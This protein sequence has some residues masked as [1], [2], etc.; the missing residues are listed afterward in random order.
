MSE[1]ARATSAAQVSAARVAV[2]L[3][4]AGL[5]LLPIG[6]WL[7][8]SF[9]RAL[10]YRA[11]SWIS[12][13]AIVALLAILLFKL[14]DVLSDWRWLC[15]SSARVL[16]AV[17]DMWTRRPVLSSILV[18]FVATSLY[19][20][21]AWLVF[22]A[23][24]LL[25]DEVV[26][27]IQARIFISG[28]L[29]LPVD[30]HPE[31]RS[32]MHM[33]EQGNRW[34]G[35]FPPGGPA[36]LAL[37]DVLHAPWI[38]NPVCAGVS[39]VA[40]AAALRWSGSRPGVSLGATLAFAFA[41]FVVFQSA[42]YMNHVTCLMW[43]LVAAAAAAY[44]A[45]TDTDAV[46]P[47]LVCG[48][49]LGAAA[50]IRPLD[51]AAWALPIAAWLAARAYRMRRWR[52][53]LSSGVGVALP[54]AIMMVV[55]ARMTGG[56]LTFGY[57]VLWGPSH[58]L[59]FHESPWGESHT[60]VRGLALT[61]AYLNRLNEY[62]FELPIP[63][64]LPALA[65]L[66]L[67]RAENALDRF[68][69][70]SAALIVGAYFAY[71]HDGFYLGPRFMFALAPLLAL[72]TARLPVIV[73]DRWPASVA[74]RAVLCAYAASALVGGTAVL[75]YR[76]RSYRGGFES[77][78][79][80]YDA[81]VARA[82]AT[83]ATILVRESWGAQVIARLWALGVSRSATEI[84]YRHVD[85]CGLD[86][87]ARKLEA[88][89]IRGAAAE[90]E[91]RTLLVDS[92]RV[93]QS[94]ASPDATERMLPGSVYTAECATRILED[95]AGYTH[96]PPA[97]LARNPG[98]KWV[99]DLHARDTLVLGT[100]PSNIWLLRREPNNS[101]WIPVLIQLVPDSLTRA[102]TGDARARPSK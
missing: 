36:M 28:R 13:T 56:P 67:S 75:P 46:L 93:V 26:Q 49:A 50:T 3:A 53:F 15:Q 65:A 23:R 14:V 80:D 52:A 86:D 74:Q 37:G 47:G 42:S 19:A 1:P 95:R 6:D 41:P 57:T 8:I 94:D 58:G 92:A 77:M 25:I 78:R 100:Q 72:L 55:N 54:F 33:V 64:L 76:I 98:T 96:F 11:I 102:W 34:Y 82:G 48:L 88:A 16:A 31:F 45:R 91:L 9:Q 35:Q 63:S 70:V 90:A 99:R 5:S 84:L 62:L 60:V 10:S 69:Y 2:V 89:G 43:L 87:T 61:A 30:A 66:L 97:L 68:L 71:W 85:T 59:G 22:D 24:P 51:A 44:S 32:I 17:V 81:I 7:H 39:V 21:T 20:V 83:G 27:L 18:A 29:W 101:D 73:R 38:V 40:F 12:G 79:W 4:L